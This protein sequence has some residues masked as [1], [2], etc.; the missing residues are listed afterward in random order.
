[1]Q[2]K[3]T[4]TLGAMAVIA[5]WACFGLGMLSDRVMPDNFPGVVYSTLRGGAVIY[6]WLA[7]RLLATTQPTAG[8]SVLLRTMFDNGSFS[9]TIN[10]DTIEKD[11]RICALSNISI[12]TLKAPR[13]PVVSLIT[14]SR[15]EARFV[16]FDPQMAFERSKALV[17]VDGKSWT[18][19]GLSDGRIFAV[20][21]N[22]LEEGFFITDAMEHG[23]Q[24]RIDTGTNGHAYSV[25]LQGFRPAYKALANCNVYLI[26]HPDGGFP[27][28]AAPRQ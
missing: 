10:G 24:L 22:F 11:L 6:S 1:M 7:P 20:P 4:A 25:D 2:R 14:D 19:T 26:D 18:L 9:V 23:K 3:L 16:V 15:F 12:T 21:I 28:G 13:H 5:F 8:G 17:V 27:R